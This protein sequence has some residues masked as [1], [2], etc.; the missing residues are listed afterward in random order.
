M[1]HKFAIVMVDV[2]YVVRTT[3]VAVVMVEI[4]VMHFV[5]VD[6]VEEVMQHL[7]VVQHRALEYAMGMGNIVVAVRESLAEKMIHLDLRQVCV[8]WDRSLLCKET[9]RTEARTKNFFFQQKI[10]SK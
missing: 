4:D 8:R 9:G 6:V 1:D 10:I 2:V 3:N 5:M 7:A